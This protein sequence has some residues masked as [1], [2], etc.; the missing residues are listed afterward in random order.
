M[1]ATERLDL[2]DPHRFA[3]DATVQDAWRR[4]AGAVLVLDRSAFYPEGGGQLA[5]RGVLHA[6]DREVEVHDVQNDGGRVL[7]YVSALVPPG[8]SISGRLDRARRLEH[9]ALHTGQHMLSRAFVDVARAETRSA[10]LGAQAATLD[11]DRPSL[12]DRLL[13]AAEDRVNEVV[14]DDRPVRTRTVTPEEAATLKL[15]RTPKVLGPV[16]IVE[17]EGFDQTPCGGTHCTRTAQVGPVKILDVH[18]HR[19]GLRVTFAAGRRTRR[20]LSAESA[21]LRDLAARF[22]CAPTDVPG[23]VAKLERELRVTRE[24]LGVARKGWAT[25]RA[26]PWTFPSSFSAS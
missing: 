23:A 2:D 25:A 8:T 18:K 11:L 20:V 3:F 15:R 10:R 22:S 1:S 17:V 21:S 9:M 7:H 6:G 16:R 12:A 4:E 19:G 13:Q 5:D 14:D 24:S 26:S